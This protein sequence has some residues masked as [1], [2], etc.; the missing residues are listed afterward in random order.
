MVAGWAAGLA[1]YSTESLKGVV[2]ADEVVDATE[3]VCWRR[4]ESSRESR[5]TWAES[6][7]SLGDGLDGGLPLL[8]ALARASSAGRTE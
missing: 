6:M 2:E 5:L 8:L 1:R 3:A 7:G 4:R